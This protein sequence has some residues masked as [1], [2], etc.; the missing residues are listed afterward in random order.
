MVMDTIIELMLKYLLRKVAELVWRLIIRHVHCKI[1]ARLASESGYKSGTDYNTRATTT[2][3]DN[4]Y[5]YNVHY[6]AA[7]Q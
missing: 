2:Y 5:T 3:S 1:K 6:R 7:D 4:T